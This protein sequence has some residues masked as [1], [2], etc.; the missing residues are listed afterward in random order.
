MGDLSKHFDR[1]EF[2]CKGE[3]CAPSGHGNCGQ[4]TI[5]YELVII[6]EQVREHFKTPVI[7]SSANRCAWHN[8][9]EGGVSNSQ[10]VVGRA[11][12]IKVKGVH[13]SDVAEFLEDKASGLGRYD[14][15]THLDTR[16]NGARW[17]GA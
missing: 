15:F 3:N 9:M 2:R 7:I 14:T 17:S 5:D 16:E 10:H 11:A 8:Q 1:A 12:D 6:L 13:P 4:D